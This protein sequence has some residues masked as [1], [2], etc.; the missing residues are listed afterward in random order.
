LCPFAFGTQTIGSINRPA[1]FCG[2]VGFKPSYGRISPKGVIP[3]SKSLDHIGFFTKDV[4]GAAYMAAY[5]CENWRDVTPESRR[6]TLGIPGGPYLDCAEPVGLA[7]FQ[8]D[9]R[10]L[11]AAG[12]NV[13]TVDAIPDFEEI[14]RQ[15]ILL[16]AA[17]AARFHAAWFDQHEPLYHP[18]TVE[19]IRS[20]QT[21][22]DE[23]ITKARAY[24]LDV[25]KNLTDLMIA[26]GISVWLS[27]SARGPAPRGLEGTGDPIMNLPWTNAGLP[28]LSIPTNPNDGDLPM[29]IQLVGGWQDDERLFQYGEAI[30]AILK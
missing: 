9:C 10:R 4:T 2:V 11:S 3:L 25:R 1:A 22:S 7:H 8:E 6:P 17:E 29:A 23:D 5:L 24:R 20:G 14:R 27:P 28:T 30:E 12:F 21:Y 15:H 19:L 16:V 26:Q 18:K 13:R